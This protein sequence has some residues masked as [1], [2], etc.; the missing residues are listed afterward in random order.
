[1]SEDSSKTAVEKEQSPPAQAISVQATQLHAGQVS[2]NKLPWNPVVA[3]AFTVFLYVAAQA[4][5]AMLLY[6]AVHLLGWGSSRAE[7][8][9]TDNTL[10][11][12][13]YILLAEAFTIGGIVWFVHRHKGRMSQLGWNRPKLRYVWVALVGFGVYLVAYIAVAVLV[14]IFIPSID[15]EQKQNIGFSSVH[16]PVEL[17]LT[18]L[19]LVILPPL[20]EELVF[21]G[22][23]F[24]SLR[25]RMRF[26]W[27][28]LIT[29]ILFAIPHLQFGEGAPPLWVAAIDTLVL[30]L[31]LCYV[32]ERTGSLWSSILIHSLKNGLAFTALFLIH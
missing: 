18:F 22:F 1:M 15:M 19:S 7:A 16:G 8:W 11:Q 28:T 9:L 32:R 24:S 2:Q 6:L 13:L 25:S 29:S 4:A 26:V 14:D 3:I 31:V 5:A 12:F 17:T 10:A 30:S 21:R 27:A 23:V 20:A